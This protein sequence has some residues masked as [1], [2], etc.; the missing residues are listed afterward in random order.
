MCFGEFTDL[1]GTIELIA[2]P[3]IYDKYTEL[4]KEDKIVFIEGK[5]SIKE[6][7]KPKIII[8]K[9]K[10]LTKENTVQK[11][12]IKLKDVDEADE[13]A[14][15]NEVLQNVKG[16]L[17]SVPVYVYFEKTGHVNKLARKWWVRADDTLK[18]K[19]NEIYENENIKFV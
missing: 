1:H 14:K 3:S 10:E 17:G 5:I 2:F 15:L 16:S 7:E 9:M 19:L 8:E 18:Q 12:Y 11:V 6:G 13:I 4:L